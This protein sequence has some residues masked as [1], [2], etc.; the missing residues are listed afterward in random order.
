MT[1]SPPQPTLD[2][3]RRDGCEPCVEAREALQAVL[4]ERARRGDRIP[5]VRYRD[6]AESPALESAFGA[7][8]PVMA[9]GADELSLAVSERSI[10][11]FLDRVLGRV[12]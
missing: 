11:T 4:E 12:A 9:I 6:V 10:A 1:N 8:V 7:R 3:Y 2:F 5:R